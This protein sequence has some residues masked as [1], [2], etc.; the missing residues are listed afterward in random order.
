MPHR[1]DT[2]AAR[3]R[4][5]ALARELE[6]VKA[7]REA[8]KRE[9]DEQFAAFRAAE[10]EAA[11]DAPGVATTRQW[12]PGEALGDGFY[13]AWVIK[14]HTLRSPGVSQGTQP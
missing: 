7:E 1:D 6:E 9:N 3:A 8:L 4:A 12:L 5:D 10:S 14:P 2:E 11:G 13:Y